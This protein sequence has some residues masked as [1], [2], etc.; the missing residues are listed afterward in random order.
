MNS[1]SQLV[2]LTVGLHSPIR[3]MTHLLI[4]GKEGKA[5]KVVKADS[6]DEMAEDRGEDQIATDA[7]VCTFVIAIYFF[8]FS[9]INVL[10]GA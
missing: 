3:F 4:W 5:D 6:W 1:M 7:E 9:I 2:K 8:P 10:L